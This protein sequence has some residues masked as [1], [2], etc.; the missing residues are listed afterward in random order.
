MDGEHPLRYVDIDDAAL[1]EYPK[2]AQAAREGGRIPLVQAGGELRNPS[3][4]SIYWV[5]EE[6][7]RLGVDTFA[8]AASHEG[9]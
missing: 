7:R 9:D 1:A 3:G 4:I 6:L 2:L 5:E 8:K